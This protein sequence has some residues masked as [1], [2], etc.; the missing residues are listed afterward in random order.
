MNQRCG[1]TFLQSFDLATQLI[2]LSCSLC[3]LRVGC[4]FQAR[5]YSKRVLARKLPVSTIALC[6]THHNDVPKGAR[7]LEPK[8]E[9]NRLAALELRA[10]RPCS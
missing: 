2:A 3:K 8:Q 5:I 9:C 7:N 6:K 1:F 4:W 10:W